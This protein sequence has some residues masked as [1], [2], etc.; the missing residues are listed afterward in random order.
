MAPTSRRDELGRP[1][2]GQPNDGHV[3]GQVAEGVAG[4]VRATAGHV[5]AARRPR[6]PAH[7]LPRLAHSLVGDAARVHDRDVGRL[8]RLDVPVGHEPL[9]DL[10]DVRLRDLAAEEVG[11]ERRHRSDDASRPARKGRP[12]SRPPSASRRSASPRAP[13]ARARDSRRRP[14][15]RR[16]S[17]RRPAPPGRARCWRPRLDT[18]GRGSTSTSASGTSTSTPLA[19][20]FARATPTAVPSLSSAITGAK[21]S[22][23]AA[24]ASTPEPQ[25]T[26]T[27][28]PARAREA[29]RGRAAWSRE[30]PFRRR[31]PG[32]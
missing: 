16:R 27:S 11:G 21:P 1:L 25:P 15:L 13:G 22:F 19:A 20:A 14:Q 28:P 10:L 4:E 18:S 3:L 32:R 29:A 17:A 24:T 9:P 12:P 31:G 7:S 30:R 8:A 5:D 23:A 2:A 6:G 26:S